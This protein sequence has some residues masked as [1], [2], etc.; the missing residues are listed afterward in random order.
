[1]CAT[2]PR[3]GAGRLPCMRRVSI[4]SS[5]GHQFTACNP[6]AYQWHRGVVSIPSSSGHQFTAA[7]ADEVKTLACQFQSLLHQGISLLASG[8]RP[9]GV[10]PVWFQSLLHQGISLLCPRWRATAT[11][12]AVSIPSSSGHQFTG[13]RCLGSPL[14][15]RNRF[16]PFFIRASVYWFALALA[17]QSE[18]HGFNPFFIRASVYWPC[19]RP[20]WP[21]CNSRFQSLLHQ[22]IS[23]L[24]EKC[25]EERRILNR[26]FNP[27]FIRA[28]VYWRTE[29]ASMT[30]ANPP[31][32]SLLHQGISLLCHAY[33]LVRT[34]AQA[35]QSLLH[36][37][38]SLLGSMPRRV[39]ALEQRLFQ[40]LLH[41][42]ISL[43]RANGAGACRSRAGVSI[44]SS[45]GHQFT[46]RRPRH[47]VLSL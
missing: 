38:I 26:G 24:I 33:P 19:T 9:L 18:W 7:H 25:K 16:N 22:G 39:Q 36:Q 15:G 17:P 23:L 31:F 6:A 11:S 21:T 5:S 14:V 37:G 27:F 41:Q 30:S 45:S 29:C 44:P 12:C 35:F 46:G 40:S 20:P 3:T 2:L 8:R 4:P 32:Q 42:G 43:L 13:I 10:P 47:D 1:M 28:S 34:A